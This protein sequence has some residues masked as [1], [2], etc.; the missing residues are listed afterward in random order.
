LAKRTG[1]EVMVLNPLKSHPSIKMDDLSVNLNKGWAY[2]ALPGYIEYDK[3]YWEKYI[4]YETN[5]I[6]KKLNDF[7]CSITEKY[8]TNVLDV[9]IGS[10]IFLKNLNINKKGFDV[11]KHAVEWLKDN[12]LY[13]NPYEEENDFDGF[14]FWDVLEHFENPNDIL[15]KIPKNSY[16]ITSL[17]IFNDITKVHLSKHYRPN[18]HLCYFTSDG[19]INFFS[20][21]L[22]DCVEIRSDEIKIGR[23]DVLAFVFKK[24]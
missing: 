3:E 22:F 4:V 8:C 5:D 23:Q 19:L 18:E 16:V 11:N 20:E 10:G 1:Q 24:A 7:R 14:C 15:C 2:Q 9:G 6:C 17:P 12:N 21:L 13:H